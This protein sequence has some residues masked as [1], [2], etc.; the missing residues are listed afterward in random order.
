[1]FRFVCSRNRKWTGKKPN[2]KD[3]FFS[4]QNKEMF[5]EKNERM[6]WTQKVKRKK[7]KRYPLVI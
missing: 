7:E 4:M 6:K 5:R 2:E 3:G 1:M